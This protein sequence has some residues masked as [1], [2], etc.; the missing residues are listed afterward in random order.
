MTG[1]PSC[2]KPYARDAVTNN[3]KYSIL[4]GTQ[5]TQLYKFVCTIPTQ[6][7]NINLR[8]KSM[9]SRL[10]RHIWEKAVMLFYSSTHTSQASVITFKS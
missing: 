10:L 6:N 4:A 7:N 5:L 8:F 1:C 2:R 9:F 3:S